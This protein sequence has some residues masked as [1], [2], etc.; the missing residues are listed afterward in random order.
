M[1]SGKY[2]GPVSGIVAVVCRHMIVMQG[3]VID[4]DKAER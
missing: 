4:L 1:G 3:G 2:K